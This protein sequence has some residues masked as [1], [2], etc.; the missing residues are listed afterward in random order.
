MKVSVRISAA[1]PGCAIGDAPVD[2]E[3]QCR[4]SHRR[5]CSW[6]SMASLI[7]RIH[8]ERVGDA[9][10]SIEPIPQA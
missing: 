6:K 9:A 10:E 7:A 8:T 2:P 1:L 3:Q 5:G 4:K